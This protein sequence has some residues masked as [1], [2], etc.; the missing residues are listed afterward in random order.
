M[1]KLLFNDGEEAENYVTNPCTAVMASNIHRVD[2]L[3]HSDHHTTRD[4]LCFTLSIRNNSIMA[5]VEELHCSSLCMMG[6]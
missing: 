3:T 4:K 5:T 6:P 2:K 1:A